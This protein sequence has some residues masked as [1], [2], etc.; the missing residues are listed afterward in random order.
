MSGDE[1]VCMDW[2]ELALDLQKQDGN[3]A[4]MLESVEPTEMAMA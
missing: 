1:C 4:D 2:P 3:D